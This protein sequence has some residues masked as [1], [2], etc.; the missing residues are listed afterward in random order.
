LKAGVIGK[1]LPCVEMKRNIL[2][3]TILGLLLLGIMWMVWSRSQLKS[4]EITATE[5]RANRA[6]GLYDYVVDVRTDQEW[7]ERHLSN[8]IHIPVGSLVTELPR[9]ISNK[10][11]RILF[12]CQRGVRASGVVTMAQKMGYTN[13]QAM[14]GNYAEL[15]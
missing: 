7:S 11:A 1:S 3:K 9:R 2:T 8:T 6:R 5:A 14:I 10:D 4:Q 15:E 13:V 12:V